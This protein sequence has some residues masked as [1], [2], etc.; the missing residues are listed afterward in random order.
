MAVFLW[1]IVNGC[2]SATWRQRAVRDLR[3]PLAR[4]FV[5][6][7]PAIIQAAGGVSR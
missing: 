5:G 2:I 7:K 6:R 4:A 1:V 3:G